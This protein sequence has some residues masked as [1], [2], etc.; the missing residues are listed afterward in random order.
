[1]K[2]VF[3]PGCALILYKPELV[4]KLRRI[5]NDNV[6]K[7]GLLDLCCRN[8][9]RLRRDT[10]V[11]SICPG[12]DKRYRKNYEESTTISLWELLAKSGFSLSQIIMDKK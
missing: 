3:A 10:E 2:R 11:I 6:G 1:M 5:L 12:C 9:P 8:Q 7:M 4:E